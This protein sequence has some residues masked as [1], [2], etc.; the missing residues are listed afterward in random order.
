MA[1]PA[2]SFVVPLYRSAETIGTV[3]RE[4]EAMDIPGGH[5]IV[6]VHD[7]SGEETSRAA[8]ELVRTARVPVTLV[9]H[10]R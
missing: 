7:G 8:R 1:S 5:E 2:L 4:I 6:L 9:E 10:A 3:V